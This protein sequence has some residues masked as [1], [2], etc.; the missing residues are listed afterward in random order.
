MGGGIRVELVD[1]NDLVI[2]TRGKVPAVGREANR[3]DG[4]EVMAHMA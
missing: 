3:V 2:G 1:A 4:S